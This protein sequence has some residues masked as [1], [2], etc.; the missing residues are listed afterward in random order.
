MKEILLNLHMHSTLSDGHKS[1]SQIAAAAGQCELDVIIITD[2]N[3]FPNGLEGYY[4][5]PSRRVLVLTG[6]E[7][8]DQARDPQKNHLL[9]FNTRQDLSHLGDRTQV[10]V[11][12]INQTGGMA[13]IAHPVEHELK[14][15]GE[16]D[17][18]WV[19][20]TVNGITGLELW[21]GLSEIKNVSSNILEAAFYA[22]FPA[23]LAHHPLPETLTIWD[24]LLKKGQ[25]MVAV[26][27]ADAHC[28][29]Y[30]IGP[31]TH[32]VLPYEYHFK[33][34]NNHLL[35]PQELSGKAEVDK[36][37]I[38]QA[39]KK[40]CSFIG[41]DL[42]HST[43][44]FRFT[45]QGASSTAEIGDEITVQGGI[46]FQIQIPAQAKILLI[47]DGQVVQR[48][49]GSQVGTYTTNQPGAYRVE[50]WI[51]FLGKRRGWIFSNPIYVRPG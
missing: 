35:L 46:T 29:P 33:S 2:H 51:Q 47:R 41:Y 4:D 5:T 12:R 27:G 23:Y 32:D 13:F 7:I 48:W 24:D 15:F 25:R 3:V 44:G 36:K 21:N 1:Y 50:A 39:L 28:I 16:P 18:S 8:H 20:W 11:D 49:K 34:I 40:G 37:A 45:A 19:D 42:P 43:R 10:L 22:L 38:Y 31:F 26:G 30:H 9:V 14:A 17:I 6:E